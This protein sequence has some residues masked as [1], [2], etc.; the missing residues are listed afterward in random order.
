MEY[1][2]LTS[3]EEFRSVVELEKQV[4]EYTDAEDVV[5]V[6]ILAVN[7]K[8]G[9]I[10]IGA[11]DESREMVG[12]VYSLPGVRRGQ[13]TQWSH[14]LGVIEHHRSAGIGKELKFQ[15][16]VRAL[17][18]GVDLIEWTFDPL[19]AMNAHLNFC[20]L[21]VI[22]SEYEEN[23]YGE[24]SSP[25]HSGTPTDRLVAEWWIR[26]DRVEQLV[27]GS[28]RPANSK[29]AIVPNEF[30]NETEVVDGWLACKDVNL[31]SGSTELHLEIPRDFSNMQVQVPELAK[32]WRMTVRE[33]F[34]TYFS[35]GYL[36][37]DFVLDRVAGRGWYVLRRSEE[38]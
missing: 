5:P 28:K 2:D 25:L 7:V 1:Q 18:M 37:V 9:G 15:Q 22:V 33:L 35:Q 4:W 32:H 3:L 19:Q 21:G 17:Q 27:A 23:I 38:R 20:K 8:R 10:L 34:K 16:R 26:T 14:M 36:A 12:F 29:A 6:P 13:L 30:L 11:F 24:S 31:E